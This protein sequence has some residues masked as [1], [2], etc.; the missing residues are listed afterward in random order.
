M[1]QVQRLGLVGSGVSTQAGDADFAAMAA[2]ATRL[3]GAE[4]DAELTV[5][6]EDGRQCGFMRARLDEDVLDPGLE[7][8]AR[9][10]MLFAE[11]MGSL[12]RQLPTEWL[13]PGVLIDVTLPPSQSPRGAGLDLDFLPTAITTMY[14]AY[15]GCRWHFSC[16]S[17]SVVERLDELAAADWQLLILA[18][19]DSLIDV[20]TFRKLAAQGRLMLAASGDGIVPGEAAAAVALARPA[21][22][23]SPAAW[24]QGWQ[25]LPEAAYR[26]AQ[27]RP[28]TALRQS[29]EHALGAA[30]KTP[31]QVGSIWH[32]LGA[33]PVGELEWFQVQRT[34]WPAAAGVPV[35]RQLRLYEAFGEVGADSFPLQLAL[36][37]AYLRYERRMARFGFPDPGAALVCDTP[38]A[39]VRGALC[40]SLE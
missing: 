1:K 15:Q 23:V 31:Q 36:A 16:G 17:A 25:A 27:D 18:G 3:S 8:S 24:L 6:A 11:A 22:V 10:S 14:P 20:A 30:E 35:P 38:D 34:L 39:P 19:A 40:M 37:C 12:L 4:A 29:M 13:G 2:V 9:I 21:T 28:Q 33:E 26:Q 5:A 7:P 32:T